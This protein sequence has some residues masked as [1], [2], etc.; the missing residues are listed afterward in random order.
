MF[1]FCTAAP[2]SEESS[3]MALLIRSA[4]GPARSG[5]TATERSCR[6]GSTQAIVQML[7]EMVESADREA[8]RRGVVMIY[9]LIHDEH[10]HRRLYG[11]QLLSRVLQAVESRASRGS[12][13]HGITMLCDLT[14]HAILWLDTRS[15][16]KDEWAAARE[17]FVKL[18]VRISLVLLPYFFTCC[19]SAEHTSSDFCQLREA[20][21]CCR[22][23]FPVE[24][25]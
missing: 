11:F 19:L 9:E 5:L 14:Q 22:C 10:D 13:Q 15:S 6:A 12:M 20:N 3:N 2:M 21:P 1:S 18:F 4:F 16:T 24:V 7:L 17:C 8:R 23:R 25:R